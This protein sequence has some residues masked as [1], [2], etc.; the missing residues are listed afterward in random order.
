MR[1]HVLLLGP[2]SPYRGGPALFMTYL[3]EA[4]SRDFR[5]DFVNFRMMYPRLLFPGT[6]PIDISKTAYPPIP[7]P[8][9][10]HTLHPWYWWKTALYVRRMNPDLIVFDWYQPF[11][12]P[13]YWAIGWLLP[14]TLRARIVMITE[15]VIS[16]EARPIDRLLTRMG[17]LWA[18][19]F[20]A[21]SARVHEDL[22][23]FAGN[24]KIHRSELPIFREIPAVE[25]TAGPGMTGKGLHPW[26]AGTK[27]LLFF[28]YIRHYKGLDILLRALA[29]LLKDDAAFALLIAGECYE[30]PNVYNALIRE[31]HLDQRV[32]FRNAYIPNEEVGAWFRA[33][34][35]VVLPYRSATQSG[36]LNLAYG[37]EKPVV[38]T[39]VGGLGEF[40]E[41]G[42]TGVMVDEATPSSLA[43]GIARFYQL[44]GT[45]DFAAHIRAKA[46]ANRFAEI[47]AVFRQILF[48]PQDN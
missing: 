43:D 42:K 22:R 19:Q 21:L 46:G 39:R 31:L 47:G 9:L 6:T 12:G 11:F 14:K 34:D 45:V 36:I 44:S 15:N 28:G 26:P 7:G 10:L 30:D 20:L 23:P 24:R 3:Y 18:R 40:V 38:C 32:I 1:P 41:D 4:L 35:V 48:P 25:P 27:V 13:M 37:L 8:R 2:A 33:A 16:H 5:V 29:L 17:L